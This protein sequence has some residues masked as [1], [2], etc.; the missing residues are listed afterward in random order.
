VHNLKYQ[1]LLVLA[2][3]CNCKLN[4]L[5]NLSGHYSIWE[6]VANVGGMH[7]AYYTR[8]M[9][10]FWSVTG[11]ARV[12]SAQQLGKEQQAILMVTF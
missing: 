10:S 1:V 12:L 11:S 2:I 3:S 8:A 7:T 6:G 5:Q 9:L 4:R